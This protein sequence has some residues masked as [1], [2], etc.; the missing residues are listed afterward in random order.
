MNDAHGSC[1]VSQLRSLALHNCPVNLCS[2]L[3]NCRE[4]F[5]CLTAFS[6]LQT[7]LT[8]QTLDC[9]RQ[10][11]HLTKLELGNSAFTQYTVYFHEQVVP[12]LE[13]LGNRLSELTLEK[14]KFVDIEAIG[15]H[16]PKLQTLRLSRVLSFCNT[17]HS[18]KFPLLNLSRL[19]ILNT[20]GCRITEATLRLLLTSRYLSQLTLQ[21]VDT[22]TDQFLTSLLQANPM[23]HLHTLVLQQCHSIS[24]V[25]LNV[26]VGLVSPLSSLTLA[27]CGMV[28]EEDRDK[29]EQMVWEHNME[30]EL[31]WCSSRLVPLLLEQEHFE[32]FELIEDWEAV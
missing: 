1:S 10:L 17:E 8:K 16:C 18:A 6:V 24:P 29:L 30:L 13:S 31:K 22:L 3:Q 26:L 32:E 2:S 4:I 27:S 28:E 5:P 23:D 19:T 9:V 11:S 14:F 7:D 25:I 21:A 15:E 20:K 12:V